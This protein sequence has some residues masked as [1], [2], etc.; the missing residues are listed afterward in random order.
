MWWPIQIQNVES[1]FWD[2][3]WLNDYVFCI[4]VFII[5]FVGGCLCGL[6]SEGGIFLNFYE[7][8]PL[9]FIWTIFP[10]VILIFIGFPRILILYRHS[11]DFSRDLSLKITG[12]Q[13]YWSYDYS[14]FDGVEFDRF[15]VPL[16]SLGWGDFRLLEVD[17]RAVITNSHYSRLIV[18]SGDVLHSWAIPRIALKVD[19]CPGRLNF[20]F[21]K[22]NSFGL[23]FGQCREI[24]GANHRFIPIALE[25][26]SSS[27]FSQ[28]LER[29]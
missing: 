28:W 11:V 23:Y 7:N 26:V 1:T 2:Y 13:W 12:H 22:P 15:M 5:S 18:T 6:F 8:R 16:C 4:L 24:C 29:F 19:A 9:E 27:L 17:N 3:D 25:V 20:L 21:V 10:A 14:D